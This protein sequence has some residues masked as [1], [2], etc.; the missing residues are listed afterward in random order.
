MGTPQ[1]LFEEPRHTFVGYF[2]GS[3]GMNFLPCILDGDNALI[4]GAA[5]S[6]EPG[7]ASR[8][9]AIGGPLKL[10]VRPEFLRL[11]RERRANSVPVLVADVED[12]GQYKIATVRLAGH[13]IKVKVPEAEET[14]AGEGFLEFRPRSTKLY[15]NDELV[16]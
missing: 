15:A 1:E 13:R 4:D 5:V 11:R 10:G 9:R 7:L 8:A 14:P 16:R 12:L 3:P 2:I 6:L